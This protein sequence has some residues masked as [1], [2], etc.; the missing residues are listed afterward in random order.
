MTTLT[1]DRNP[2]VHKFCAHCGRAKEPNANYVD[3]CGWV[4][5]TFVFCTNCGKRKEPNRNY[6]HDEC[7]CR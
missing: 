1:T 7:L 4:S 6:V 3:D 2:V 5:S